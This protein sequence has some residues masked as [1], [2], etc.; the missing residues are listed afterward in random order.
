MILIVDFDH[1][2]QFKKSCT[3]S[4]GECK[5]IAKSLLYS[6]RKTEGKKK[7]ELR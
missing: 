3:F 6:M 1:F 5:G 4:F 2:D 7:R